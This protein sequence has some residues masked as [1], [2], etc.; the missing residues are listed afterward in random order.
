M[1]SLAHE[2]SGGV[3][4]LRVALSAPLST[5]PPGFALQ[6]PPRIAID[7]PGTT[8]ALGSDTM[9]FQR[10]VLREVSVT[11]V[12]GRTRLVLSLRQPVGW[13]TRLDGSVI[14]I[15]LGSTSAGT[16][17]V[18]HRAVVP[19][20]GRVA[21]V[22]APSPSA[23]TAAPSQGASMTSSPAGGASAGAAPGTVPLGTGASGPAPVS[24]PVAAPTSDAVRGLDF[25]RAE[26]GAG[27]LIVSLPPSPVDV[28]VRTQGRQLR[29][30]LRGTSLPSALQQ[31][32]DVSDFGTP[33]RMVTAMQA[34]D[35][36]RLL[37]DAE[38]TWEH[39]AWQTREAFVLEVRPPQAQAEGIAR[40]GGPASERISLNFQ[41][42]EVRALLQVIADFTNLN[43][44]ASDSVSGN[45]TLRLKDVPWEEALDLILQSKGLAM[46][47]SGNVLRVAPSDELNAQDQ[48]T[49]EA[50]RKLS[51]LEPLRTQAFAL[52]YAK[53]EDIARAL[54]GSGAGGASAAAGGAA[55]G[56]GAATRILSARGSLIHEARTNQLFVTDIGSRL[57]QVQALIARV[58]IPV[59]QVLIEARIVEADDSFGRALGV[60]LGANDLRGL[61]GGV[62]GFAVG[63][64]NN[65][66]I[67]NSYG[68]IGAQTR[69]GGTAPGFN[70]SAFVNLPADTSRLAGGVSATF[71]LSLFSPSAN[72]FLNLELSALEAEGR[73]KI[74][75]SPRVITADQV[76][77]LIEQGE[78]LPF[79]Q[80][81]S[82][83]ATSVQFKK[84]NLR[85]EV[86]PQITPEGQVI[87]DVDVSKDSVGRV[88]PAGFAIDTRHVRTQV[89]V[90]NGGTVVIG[91]IFTQTEKEDTNKVPWLGDA[92]VVG[93]LFRN[94]ARSVAKTELLVFLTPKVITDPG[95]RR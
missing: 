2:L 84:A 89:L 20:P 72:R 39:S 95:V 54:L 71:A 69:Q 29:I 25:R 56:G 4:T 28:D 3:E 6:S 62:P 78:E 94:R 51:D 91:G 61:Q 74:V 1:L 45:L 49:L 30:D 31:R 57:E 75:S 38:G 93:A 35:L 77:A 87:L 16:G 90:D 14:E 85:L 13:Q 92:P 42:I 81:T 47:R 86:T 65:V 52:N 50:R 32:Y 64:G 8:S 66:A 26:Q 18:P 17:A 11:P 10:G 76:K 79:Q 41:N 22:T 53:A 44:I 9:G 73:G 46:R 63:G 36:V 88:T 5:I 37:V 33:V 23:A 59:R 82:S 27:R 24:A 12:P 43:I 15:R 48:A 83:G 68:A 19:A 58:D 7:L 80:A 40:V 55:G 60:K 34:G 70:D 21:T 67:G